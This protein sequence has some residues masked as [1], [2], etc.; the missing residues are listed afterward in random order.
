MNQDIDLNPLKDLLKSSQS[1]LI[2]LPQ[3]PEIDQVAAGLALYLSF[4]KMALPAQVGCANLMTVKF[5]RLFGVNKITDKI[6]QRNLVISFDY[7]KDAIE[8]VSYHID[9]GKFN[10]VIEPKTGAP[11]LDPKKVDYFHTGA[12]AD[13]VFVLG[14]NQLADL[15]K[16]YEDEK[17][18]FEQKPIVNISTQ[19]QTEHFGKFNLI[20]DTSCGISQ[21]VSFL[22]KSLD[23]PIDQDIATN[24][25][26]GLE[27]ATNNFSSDKV[28]AQTFKLAAFLM[29]QGASQHQLQPAPVVQ[30][31]LRDQP[32][33]V[34]DESQDQ[35]K[36][37][38]DWF[39]P[40]VFKGNTQF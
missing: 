9:K 5:N 7:V 22:F 10:L 21:I 24:L 37:S 26:A 34:R 27:K 15:G 16:F 28:S 19:A 4:K 11:T 13:L 23:L 38:P 35:V 39:K 14:V 3:N 8:R 32:N 20:D 40:K 17:N 12:D 36:P 6:G 33:P 29:E 31:T 1:V 2:L 18:L 25:L 30:P